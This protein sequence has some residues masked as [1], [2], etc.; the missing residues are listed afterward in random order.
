MAKQFLSP[1]D[2][3]STWQQSVSQSAFT[4]AQ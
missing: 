1:A 3:R 2:L 4:A